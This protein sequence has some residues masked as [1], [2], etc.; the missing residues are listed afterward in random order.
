[1]ETMRQQE[2]DAEQEEGTAMGGGEEDEGEE[3]K[4]VLV[5]CTRLRFVIVATSKGSKAL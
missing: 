4:W 1:M 2:K 3:T 5:R